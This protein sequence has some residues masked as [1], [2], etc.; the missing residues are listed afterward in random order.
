MLMQFGNTDI[1]TSRLG[2][3][4]ARLGSILTPLDRR[5][6]LALVE[7]AYDYGIRHFDTANTYGQ[8]DSERHLGEALQR[9]RGSVCIASKA[10]HR[11]SAKQAVLGCLKAPLRALLRS[12]GAWRGRAAAQ[13]GA[14]AREP[15]GSFEPA[16][17]ESSLHASLRRL[18]TDY[19]DIFYLHH[20][21]PEVLADPRIAALAERLLRAGK[22]RAFGVYCDDAACARAAFAMPA[23]Q[24]V[25][26]EADP[27]H[28]HELLALAARSGKFCVLK[29][30]SRMAATSGDYRSDFVRRLEAVM[31][32]EPP[33]AILVS[34]TQV[35]HLFENVDLYW[36]TRSRLART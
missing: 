8:G 36:R 1:V 34:S 24:I 3:S 28:D 6:C 7:A 31:A 11:L 9:R 16:R 5:G 20:P 17:L 18:R 4:C 12:H 26:F 13:A 14:A 21:P 32:L 22:V 2:L 29:R 23:A 35:R 19:L 27:L 15:H 25:Q 10:G 33:A 30:L